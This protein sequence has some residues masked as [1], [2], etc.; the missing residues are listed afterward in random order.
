M[1]AIKSHEADRFLRKPASQI[2][3]Y[4]VCGPDAGLVSER[5]NAVIRSFSNNNQDPF[6]LLRIGGDELAATPGRLADEANTIGL[7]G[8][9][10]CIHIDA[11]SKSFVPALESL[12]DNP[13]T[14]CVVVISAGDL[15][16]DAPLR[17]LV[18]RYSGGASIEC[19]ADDDKQLEQIIDEEMKRAGISIT[20]GA[21]EFLSNHLGV[22]RL[23]TWSE[24]QKLALHATGQERVTEQHVEAIIADAARL[25]MDD[26]IFVA[27]L[28]DYRATTEAATRSLAQMDAGVLIGFILRHVLFLHRLRSELEQ[29][30]S[31]ETISE[32]LPRSYFGS[33]KAQ[34]LQQLRTW[35]ATTL[36]QLASDVADAAAS[37]R[38]DPKAAERLAI[39]CLW[40][41]VRGARKPG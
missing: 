22:D 11:G 32:R 3:L 30:G 10:R 8:G 6:A 25:N 7:F 26:A 27:F 28:G 16:A 21:R 24:L 29:G 34:L 36:L 33:K 13:P 41:I 18:S 23:V 4:L 31:I 2:W 5:T 20:P 9:S 19:Y 37:A 1:V 39:R 15:K 40:W 17:K 14:G 35:K 12:I 38:R